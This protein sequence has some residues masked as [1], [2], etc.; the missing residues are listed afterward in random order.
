MPC[1]VI[2]TVA[3]KQYDL[4]KRAAEELGLEEGRDFTWSNGTATLS[5]RSMMGPLK[6]RYGLLETE[7]QVRKKGL[8]SKRKTEEDGTV[9]LSV[10]R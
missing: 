1:Y 8:T 7:R 6:Q 5:Q 10:M 3:L 9:T 2:I 4:A